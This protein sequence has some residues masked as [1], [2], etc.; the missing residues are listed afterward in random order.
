VGGFG[1]FG[2]RGY[3]FGSCRSG[4]RVAGR[5]I[6]RGAGV[7]RGVAQG[8][9]I[10]GQLVVEVIDTAGVGVVDGRTEGGRRRLQPLQ[11]PGLNEPGSPPRCG[12]ERRR[13]Q[14]GG[15]HTRH[16][17]HQF[18]CL[19]DDKQFVLGQYRGVGDRVDGQQ[20]VIGDDDV[21]Q[22]GLGPCPLGEALTAE[23]A[24]GNP[25]AFPR[26]HTDL[27]PGPVGHSGSQLI[28]VTGPGFCGPQRQPL[29]ICA[30]RG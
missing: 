16:A 28:A 19:V 2:Q 13:C 6:D 4:S 18:M 15:R 7:A 1:D 17:V 27:R 5:R 11:E 26:A 9:Q 8:G 12:P 10:G 30:Q 29:H 3:R 22:G 25:Y 23:R 14:L 21:G 24:A 20:R